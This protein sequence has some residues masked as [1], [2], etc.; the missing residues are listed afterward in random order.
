MK[1]KYSIVQGIG[2]IGIGS[3]LINELS[4]ARDIIRHRGQLLDREQLSNEQLM[5]VANKTIM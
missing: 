4:E 5:L 1:H 2:G 3:Y